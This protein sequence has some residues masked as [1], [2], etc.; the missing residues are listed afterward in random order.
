MEAA[1]RQELVEKLNSQYYSA[2]GAKIS[3]VK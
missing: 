2:Q 3:D 1:E